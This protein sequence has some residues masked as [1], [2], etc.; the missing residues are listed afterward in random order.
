MSVSALH[1]FLYGTLVG[2]AACADVPAKDYYKEL[3][4]M[5]RDGEV[6]E[7]FEEYVDIVCQVS[8]IMIKHYD[9]YIENIWA[10]EER[11]IKEYI[12]QV[13]RL[14][15]ESGFTDKAEALVGCKLPNEYFTA[16]L[17]TSVEN[18]AE[19]IDISTEQDVFGIERTPMDGFYFIGHEFIIYLL[20]TALKDE[21][22]FQSFETWSITEGLAEYYL[23]KIMG[24]TRFFDGQQKVVKFFEECEKEGNLSAVELYRRG[25]S[26]STIRGK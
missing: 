15:E 5:V 3:L 17:V 23:K 21:N 20:F 6:P 9:H 4:R 7:G 11:K 18:G 25:L 19:A 14:F 24:D 8:D 16:T 2:G 13:L 22:S 12:P 10:E 26:A 1:G